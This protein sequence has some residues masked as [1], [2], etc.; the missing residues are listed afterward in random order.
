MKKNILHTIHATGIV[1][2]VFV[3]LFF[4]TVIPPLFAQDGTGPD[5]TGG[6]YNTNF[7]PT[8]VESPG[9]G[10]TSGTSQSSG[11]QTSQTS[12]SSRGSSDSG[13]VLLQ[14][15]LVPG[16][17]SAQASADP[18]KYL[19][20]LF[21]LAIGLG[22][23]IAVVVL[24]WGGFEYVASG[25]SPSLRDD[26]KK[27]ITAAL[28]GLVLLVFSITLAGTINKS[29]TSF[30]LNLENLGASAPGAGTTQTGTGKSGITHEE[31]KEELK[32]SNVEVRST[33]QC[34]TPGV[35]NCTNLAGVQRETL[36]EIKRLAASLG[37]GQS[38]LVCWVSGGSEP[39]H[40]GGVSHINGSA[41]DFQTNKGNDP[42]IEYAKKNAVGDPVNTQWGAVYTTKQSAGGASYLDE[43]SHVHVQ[44]NPNLYV[45]GGK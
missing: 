26:A 22:G 12:N 14:E 34:E 6:S 31:V 29:F 2:G 17:G 10:G 15:T 39:G 25:A 7:A 23:V 45:A 42:I 16:Q 38:G 32:R 43:K 9:E 4:T 8:G 28:G 3:F 41:V 40:K 27:R 21:Q 44:G 18:G 36:E 30:S 1:S 33:G 35:A 37:C 20:G 24:M 19:A 11:T 13:V 5:P